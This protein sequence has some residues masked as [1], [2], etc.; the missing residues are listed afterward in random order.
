MPNSYDLHGKFAVVAG[1][2]KRIG[3]G[4]TELLLASGATV[5]IRDANPLVA[6]PGTE[7]TWCE[8]D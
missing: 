5:R 3:R 4:I 7:W 2:A 6:G 1:G 8:A